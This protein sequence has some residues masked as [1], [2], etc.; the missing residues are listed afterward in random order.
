MRISKQI[1]RWALLVSVVAAFSGCGSSPVGPAPVG[2]GGGGTGGDPNPAAMGPPILVVHPDG[3][4]SWTQLPLGA[5]VK[6]AG[7]EPG[8]AT[9]RLEVVEQVDGAAGA[10]MRCG[11]F[12]LMIPP[13][14]FDG[15]GSVTMSMEDS[16]VMVC[17]LE[18]FPR[19]LNSFREPVHLALCVNDTDASTDTLSIYWNDPDKNEWVSM[20]CDKD[21]SAHA[22]TAS[23][24]FPANA[25]GVMTELR[26][27]SRYSAGKAGW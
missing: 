10:K 6:P 27:F 18:I 5:G 4:T 22:E 21:L 8:V 15:S 24:P 12:Y 9:N 3:T 25:R 17:N 14:T 19:E 13:G 7:T 16:T 20:T 23:A 1:A 11:R 2:S 26:H